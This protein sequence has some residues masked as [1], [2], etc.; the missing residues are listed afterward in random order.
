MEAE[1]GD[2]DFYVAVCKTCGTK[3]VGQA[4][5]TSIIW[6]IPGDYQ[7]VSLF[8]SNFPSSSLIVGRTSMF[9]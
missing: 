8:T 1:G 7:P 2:S 6:H 9:V 5:P 4:L 3:S